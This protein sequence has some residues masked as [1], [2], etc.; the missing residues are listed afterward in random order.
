MVGRPVLAAAPWLAAFCGGVLGRSVLAGPVVAVVP[1]IVLLGYLAAWAWDRVILPVWLGLG[2]GLAVTA[3]MVDAG[4]YEPTSVT[5]V[6]LEVVVVLVA[7]VSRRSNRRPGPPS[8][9]VIAPVSD[10][11]GDSRTGTDVPPMAS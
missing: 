1:T 10:D 6:V 5:V 8:L 2:V 7:V 4:N 9:R 3:L 11:D